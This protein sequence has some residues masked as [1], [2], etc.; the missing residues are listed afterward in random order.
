[1]CIFLSLSLHPRARFFFFFA[2]FV[3]INKVK[4]MRVHIYNNSPYFSLSLSVSLLYSFLSCIVISSPFFTPPPFPFLW[5]LYSHV[6]KRAIKRI[7]TVLPLTLFFFFLFFV[8]H[9]LFSTWTLLK[10]IAFQILSS[11]NISIFRHQMVL[12]L[13]IVIS[14]RTIW[15]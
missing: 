11:Q 12:D 6:R 8:S 1:M 9:F 2:Y 4:E 14:V 13:I 5:C 15:W 7:Y 10:T 3:W